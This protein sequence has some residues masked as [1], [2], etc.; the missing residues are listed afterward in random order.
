MGQSIQE[1]TKENFLKAVYHKFTWSILEYFDP[2]VT[3]PIIS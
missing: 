2:N 1:W 3:F